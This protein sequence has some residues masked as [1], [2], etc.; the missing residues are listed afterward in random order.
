MRILTAF[1]LL[2][3]VLAGCNDAPAK[4]PVDDADFSDIDVPVSDTT[5]AIR[6][7]V[8]DERI[9]PVQDAVVALRVD[10]S[11]RNQSTDE[12]GRF[13]FGNLVP[14]TYF[15]TVRGPFHKEAQTSTEVRAGE[16]EPPL[17]KVQVERLFSADPFTTSYKHDG[18][19]EC[20]Q[21]GVLLLIYSS[22]N[23]VTDYSE[24]STNP[25]PKGV[26]PQLNNVT[27]QQRQWQNTVEP[28]WQSLV[29]EMQ[30]QPT[31][32]GTS[33]NLGMT[34]STDFETRDKRFFY[35]SQAGGTPFLLRLDQGVEHDTAQ[36]PDDANP[37]VLGPEGR[38]DVSYFVSV[39]EGDL[40]EPAVALN[41]HFS[42]Y[43]TQFYY[44][45]APADWSLVA[46]SSIPY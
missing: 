28:G 34:V 44:L 1:L 27:T 38:P 29:W 43:Y 36:T 22:S 23:C 26:A 21:A 41:Q 25:G 30:W 37:A 18:F 16:A 2:A 32:Q 17:V 19:F 40:G 31:S 15:L 14:G 24:S 46:G 8:V 3:A 6:G 35:A 4:T 5:G 45:P 12:Q 42:V 9:I 39:R 13:A 11:D 10:G 20:S 33:Q 7:I